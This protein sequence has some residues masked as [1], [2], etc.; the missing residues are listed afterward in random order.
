M[1]ET[2]KKNKG[3]TP[4]GKFAL[5]NE[6][7]KARS[8]HGPNPKFSNPED[9]WSACEEYFQWTH[10]N[11]LMEAKLTSYQGESCI[12]QIPKNAGND[13]GGASGLSR[14]SSFNLG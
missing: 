14:Y 8:S 3:H 10:D 9:L 4:D 13:A 2:N 12:E 11:P 7:W 5:G 6:F 1:N